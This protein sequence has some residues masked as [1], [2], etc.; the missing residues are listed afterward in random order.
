MATLRTFVAYL[1]SDKGS[2][3]R[4]VY[5]VSQADAMNKIFMTTPEDVILKSIN[6]KF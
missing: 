5:A 3:R 2:E 6:E 1:I 4:E